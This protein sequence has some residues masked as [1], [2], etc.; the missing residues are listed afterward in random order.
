MSFTGL[1]FWHCCLVYSS[2]PTP[3]AP[4]LPQVKL[5]L[6]T[7][8]QSS[9]SPWQHHTV[10]WNCPL[11]TEHLRSPQRKPV[12]HRVPAQFYQLEI[13]VLFK[14]KQTNK[15]AAH[16]AQPALRSAPH[17]VLSSKLHHSFSGKLHHL[18]RSK[19]QTWALSKNISYPTALC[20]PESW[21]P[22]NAHWFYFDRQ[23]ESSLL[24]QHFFSAHIFAEHNHITQRLK[25]QLPL[26]HSKELDHYILNTKG[27]LREREREVS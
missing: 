10:V 14:N 3:R 27:K 2:P 12:P 1:G 22:L 6:W 15:A 9:S 16:G 26:N 24:L 8:Q 17:P 20:Q 11:F 18:A 13:F 19:S 4:P 7:P 5:H 23:K 25:P 21:V